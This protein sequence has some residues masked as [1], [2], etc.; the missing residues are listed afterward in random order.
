M[1]AT[2][3]GEP[4]LRQ[5]YLV[6]NGTSH[7]SGNFRVKLNMLRCPEASPMIGGYENSER[8]KSDYIEHV[9]RPGP[10]HVALVS[11]RQGHDS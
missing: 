1:S 11:S 6:V 8:E 9:K 2:A 5:T 7:G 3:S 10:T 4:I